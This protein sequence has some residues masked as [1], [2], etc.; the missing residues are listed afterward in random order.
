MR[1]SKCDVSPAQHKLPQ[2]Q[3]N[4]GLVR[5]LLMTFRVSSGAS[6]QGSWLPC[7]L[8]AV[9]GGGGQG[10][11]GPA[12][13]PETGPPV[14]SEWVCSNTVCVGPGASGGGGR[15]KEFQRPVVMEAP[16]YMGAG[17][18]EGTGLVAEGPVRGK[19]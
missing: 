19:G 17:L 8:Q 6:E 15:L 13:V 2:Q 4:Y 12:W 18:R 3:G 7:Q 11:W 9:P 10:A 16:M 5:D 14:W 1:C